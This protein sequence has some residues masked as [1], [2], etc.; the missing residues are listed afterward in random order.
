MRRPQLDEWIALAGAELGVDPGEVDREVL[1][2]FARCVARDVAGPAAPVALY[3]LGV[4][5]GQGMP[6]PDAISR[7]STVVAGWR[8][9]DWRD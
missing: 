7:L 2:D 1:L 9:V 6:V 4:A 8:G 5:V 3:L